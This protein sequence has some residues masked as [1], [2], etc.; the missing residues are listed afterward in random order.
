MAGTVSEQKPGPRC[1]CP[2]ASQDEGPTPSPRSGRTGCSGS[3]NPWP[4]HSSRGPGLEPPP[5]APSLPTPGPGQA[6][7]RSPATRDFSTQH[8]G[9]CDTCLSWRSLNVK[10]CLI[11]SVEN[12]WAQ[13]VS[14]SFT[15]CPAPAQGR[16]PET[17]GLSEPEA[18]TPGQRSEEVWLKA[19]G[20][21]WLKGPVVLRGITG[22]TVR[23][24]DRWAWGCAHSSPP[25]CGRPLP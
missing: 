13:G 16:S 10:L 15:V 19:K 23:G 14:A 7:P 9:V 22:N 11:Y 18:P 6:K 12:P 24:S 4:L 21:L 2:V 25:L 17:W 8:Q 3:W 20:Q 1:S 5:P